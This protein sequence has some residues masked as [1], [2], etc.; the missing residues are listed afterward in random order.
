MAY[1]VKGDNKPRVT[2]PTIDA[3]ATLIEAL[4]PTTVVC[5][6]P[7]QTPSASPSIY[8]NFQLF[9]GLKALALVHKIPMKSLPASD[10]RESV[11][12]A[13]HLS[14]EYILTYVNNLWGTATDPQLKPV[15]ELA[16]FDVWTL[17]KAT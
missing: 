11:H 5:E 4:K 12:G 3:I 6:R 13:S 2:P 14:K 15:H 1:L 8:Y 16:M 7:F 9:G 17:S 10:A